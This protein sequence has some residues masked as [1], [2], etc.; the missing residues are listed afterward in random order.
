LRQ[1]VEDYNWDNGRPQRRIDF[2]QQTAEEVEEGFGWCMGT[3][4][5]PALSNPETTDDVYVTTPYEID[6]S[7]WILGNATLTA[8]AN[9][10]YVSGSSFDAKWTAT[11]RSDG[12]LETFTLHR[13]SDYPT[14][15]FLIELLT[16]S[17]SYSLN[18]ILLSM[19]GPDGVIQ[20]IEYNETGFQPRRLVNEP[21][22]LIAPKIIRTRSLINKPKT[23]HRVP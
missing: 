5:G 22:N 12:L 8:V 1:R 23:P 18:G 9:A 21:L 3:L 13:R 2:G 15:L 16:T 14:G 20:R 19:T 17:V 10:P 6:S 7:D 11:Y 4:D